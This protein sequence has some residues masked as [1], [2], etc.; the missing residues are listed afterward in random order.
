MYKTDDLDPVWGENVDY[1]SGVLRL[2]AEAESVSYYASAG[3]VYT[4][5]SMS[6][7]EQVG[8]LIDG[9]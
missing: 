9:S 4:M 2:D 7:W 6:V 8:E 3:V 1:S 5:N